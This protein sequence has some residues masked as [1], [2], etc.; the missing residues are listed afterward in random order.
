MATAWYIVFMLIFIFA[1]FIIPYTIFFYEEDDSLALTGRNDCKKA[2]CA[3]TKY[4]VGVVVIVALVAGILFALLGQS[5]VP[6]RDFEFDMPVLLSTGD[7]GNRID[8]LQGNGVTEDL[9]VDRSVVSTGIID[10]EDSVVLQLSFPV[11]VMALMSFVGWILFVFFGGLGLVGIPIDSIRSFTTRPQRLDRGQVAVLEGGIKRRCDDLVS[12]GEQLK[13]VRQ[14][15]R[16]AIEGGE[17]RF[18]ERRRRNN[19]EA[20]EFNQFKQA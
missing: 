17:L 20:K 15:T 10:S 19:N 3:A 4:M 9:T 1:L 14:D 8:I 11:F 13:G 16:E 12:V 6:V 2:L 7:L 5:D 18:F